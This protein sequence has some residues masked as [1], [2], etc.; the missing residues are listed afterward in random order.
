MSHTIKDDCVVCLEIID[1]NDSFQ[2]SCG[3]IFHKTCFVQWKQKT[4]PVCRQIDKN[5]IE[6]F[7]KIEK[8]NCYDSVE[9]RFVNINEIE[10][11]FKKKWCVSKVYK[12]GHGYYGW[13]DKC[14]YFTSNDT[15]NDTNNVY[16][17]GIDNR[18]FYLNSNGNT[19]TR[20]KSWANLLKM[21]NKEW[22][23]CMCKC[24]Q[25]SSKYKDIHMSEYQHKSNITDVR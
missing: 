10:Y 6:Y 13:I 9:E 4:C 19:T 7:V 8:D 2:L 11:W 12:K 5:N 21:A 20:D 1:I 3:H 25:D 15:T 24:H 23:Q 16:R 18:E 17:T 14:I 22:I